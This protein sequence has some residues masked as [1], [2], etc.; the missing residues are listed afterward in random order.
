M[1][2]YCVF[3]MLAERCHEERSHFISHE[4]ADLSNGNAAEILSHKDC[5]RILLVIEVLIFITGEL[6]G[7]GEIGDENVLVDLE[8]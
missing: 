6:V 1:S 5:I 2:L 4:V 8:A 3:M 7:V